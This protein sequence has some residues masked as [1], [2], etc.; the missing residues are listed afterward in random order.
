MLIVFMGTLGM[1]DAMYMT[2]VFHDLIHVKVTHGVL[3][4]FEPAIP[5]CSSMKSIDNLYVY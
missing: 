3:F 5:R 2:G 1:M 4:L